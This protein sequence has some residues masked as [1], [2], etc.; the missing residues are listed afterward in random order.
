VSALALHWARLC[1]DWFPGRLPTEI[2]A[3]IE[4]LPEGFVDEMIESYAYAR[5]VSANHADP[6]GRQSSA[7]RTA[8]TE[9]EFEL[10]EEEIG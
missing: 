10:A 6:K 8:A 2:R 1:F 7:L 3:E 4:R 9:I 5:A